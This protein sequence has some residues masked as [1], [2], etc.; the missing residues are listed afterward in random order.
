VLFAGDFTGNLTVMSWAR[1]WRV[2]PSK[3]LLRVYPYD[4][5]GNA[6]PDSTQGS[7]PR[8]CQE[9]QNFRNGWSFF[10]SGDART[11]MKR[12]AALADDVPKSGGL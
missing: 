9:R 5:F 11:S 7:A 8:Q 2:T 3:A 12:L 6:R 1:L 10:L 4:S